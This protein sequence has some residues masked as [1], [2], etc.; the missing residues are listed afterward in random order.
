MK[1]LY[2]FLGIKNTADYV[3]EWFQKKILLQS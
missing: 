2:V 1:Y 3:N